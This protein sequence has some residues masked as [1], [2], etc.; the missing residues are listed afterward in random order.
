VNPQV[1]TWLRVAVDYGAL[2]AFAVAFGLAAHAGDKDALL[3]ATPT[4]MIGSVIAVLVGFLL[5]RRFAPMPLTYGL[6][7]IVFGGLALIFHDK[8]L[9][10]MKPTFAYLAF[11]I[12]L[13]AGL[14]LKRNPL[15]A[16]LGSSIVMPE[17]AWR[18]LT[19]RYAIFFLVSAILNEAV[20]RT[21]QQNDWIWLK[22]KLFYFVVVLLFSFA[23][24]PFLMKHMEQETPDKGDAPK[25]PE[26][27]D[28][29]F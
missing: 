24:A 25:V 4:L 15:R 1:R 19:I 11:A 27:P 2:I 22:Y 23:Q 21:T 18:T 8:T 29:G 6:F 9:V 16:M 10:K 5:E 28:A 13:G 26:P 12:A 17:P 14:V 20:W 7:A 3:T